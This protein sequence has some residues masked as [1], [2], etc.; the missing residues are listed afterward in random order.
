[1][2]NIQEVDTV[3][4][5]EINVIM[6]YE[7]LDNRQEDYQSHTI[8]VEGKIN[9]H[10]I[11]RLIDFGANHSY[12]DPK[13]VER[14]KLNICKYGKSWS[15]HLATGTKTKINELVKDFPVSMNGV[16]FKEYLNI[17]PLGSYECSIGM[18]FLDKHHAIL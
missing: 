7:S 14:F 6:I 10:P 4:D 15:V 16:G 18:D 5:V 2:H 8:E 12:I 17:I 11:A 3:D 13:L 1:M 9:N